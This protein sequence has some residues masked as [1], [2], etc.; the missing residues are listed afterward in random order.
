MT[1]RIANQYRPRTVTPPGATIQDLMDEQGLRQNELATRM[2]MSPKF[3]NELVAGKAS[4]TPPTAL[5]LERALGTPASF[6]LSREAQFQEARARQAEAE[7]LESSTD[8]L[9]EIPYK[10][11]MKFGWIRTVTRK[12]DVVAESLNFFGV[13]NVAAWREQYVEKTAVAAYRMSSAA[14]RDAG[15]VAAWLRAGERR[16]AQIDCAPF[17]KERFLAAVEWSRSLTRTVEPNEFLVAL[18]KRFSACGVAVVVVRAPARCPISGAVRWLT[19]TKALIQLSFKYL[20]NDIFWFTFFHECGHIALHGKKILF[21]ETT[22]MCGTE[23]EEADRFA[24]DRL[25]SPQDWKSFSPFSITDTNVRAFADKVGV[26]PGI[27]VGRL[28][29]EGQLAW[30]RLNNLKIRYQWQDA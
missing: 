12:V 23:E 9:Q 11:M 21:L 26:A 13:A 29:H 5:A 27:V 7:S 22:G 15:A 30:S 19:P 1:D 25:I 3:V 18:E 16:G 20:S 10:D 28:Q 14:T 2:G 24:G 8:W 17:D 6:W 4:I